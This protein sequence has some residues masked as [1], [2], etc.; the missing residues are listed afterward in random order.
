MH[1]VRPLTQIWELQG[2]HH[3]FISHRPITHTSND[4]VTSLNICRKAFRLGKFLQ[5]VNNFKKSRAT[6]HI[7]LLE[8]LAYGGEGIYYFVEQGVWLAKIGVLN[9]AWEKDLV[10]LSAWAECIGYIGSLSLS[11]IKLG[12][13]IG[14]EK[15]IVSS[16]EKK[17]RVSHFNNL[18]CS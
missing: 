2:T 1:G 18:D 6:G 4:L 8:A 14:K 7:Y 9:K 10:S 15:A 17:R 12:E 3:Q 16:L 11:F 13:L 5:D